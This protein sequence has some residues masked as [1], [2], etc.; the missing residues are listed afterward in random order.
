MM[1]LEAGTFR[2]RRVAHAWTRRLLLG[3]PDYF[4]LAPLPAVLQL[5]PHRA[6]ATLDVPNMAVGDPTDSPI[7]RWCV[8]AWPGPVPGD[9]KVV[10]RLGFLRGDRAVEVVRV[11]EDEWHLGAAH[12]GPQDHVQVASIT[13]ALG[14]D[15]T[16]KRLLTMKIGETLVRRRGWTR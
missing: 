5:V 11:A 7:W 12:E 13:T 6:T 15:P 10:S 4:P 3:I 8:D 2:L 1:E 9:A 16:L 14:I